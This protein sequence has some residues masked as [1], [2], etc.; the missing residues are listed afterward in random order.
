VITCCCII[1]VGSLLRLL[2]FKEADGK[3]WC[4]SLLL[5]LL[6]LPGRPL[7]ALQRQPLPCLLLLLLLTQL[8]SKGLPANGHTHVTP[9]SLH[10]CS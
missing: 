10:P 7:L 9:R 5:L 4:T 2:V 6:W 1:S 8:Q 3:G